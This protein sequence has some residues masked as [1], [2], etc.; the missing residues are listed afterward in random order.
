ML[1]GVASGI[2]DA[3]GVEPFVIRIAFAALT[4]FG[5]SGPLIYALCWILLPE[6]GRPESLAEHWWRNRN[7]A[8][9]VPIVAIVGAAMFLFA[10][11]GPWEPSSLWPVALIAGGVLLFQR[12]MSGR[13]GRP[14]ADPTATTTGAAPADATAGTAEPG[15]GPSEQP[16]APW[17]GWDPRPPGDSSAYAYQYATPW[18]P[19]GKAPKPAKA[20]KRERVPSFLG[21]LTFGVLLLALAVAALF[22]LIGIVDLTFAT[23]LAITL[24]V[25]GGGMVLGAWWGSGRRLILPTVLVGLALLAA[26]SD[27]PDIHDFATDG[28]LGRAHVRPDRAEPGRGHVRALGRPDGPGP[29]RRGVHLASDGRRGRWVSATWS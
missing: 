12:Q 2:A 16:G 22:D 3:L 9:W 11:I 21:R 4:V 17:T 23:G 6:R 18:P 29:V 27:G 25:L 26:H 5:G 14:P 13:A 15:E 8:S 20:R 1:G 7:Q 24:A 28:E 10:G 19:R